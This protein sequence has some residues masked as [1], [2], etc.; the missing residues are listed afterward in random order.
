M[1]RISL[2]NQRQLTFR[3]H[4]PSGTS[5]SIFMGKPPHVQNIPTETSSAKKDE[6]IAPLNKTLR[7]MQNDI[8]CLRRGEGQESRES[9]HLNAPPMQGICDHN[10]RNLRD[11]NSFPNNRQPRVHVPNVVV[12]S[13][14]FEDAETLDQVVLELEDVPFPYVDAPKMVD[15]SNIVTKAKH[16][17]KQEIP[18]MENVVQTRSQVSRQTKKIL[19]PEVHDSPR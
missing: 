10:E 18:P 14:P 7:Q 4:E 13:P 17:S 19:H 11:Q 15:A 16:P 8:T 3:G 1:Q 6:E 9:T 2:T 12:M 5:K